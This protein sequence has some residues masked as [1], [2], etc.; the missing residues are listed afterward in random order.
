ML[1]QCD[2]NGY[3]DMLKVVTGAANEQ[4]C[5]R[6]HEVGAAAGKPYI[7]L[8]LGAEGALSRVLNKRFTPVT[9]KLLTIAAPGELGAI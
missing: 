7:G 8:C 4:D 1:Q 9:H 3:A 5:L 2:L 6:V